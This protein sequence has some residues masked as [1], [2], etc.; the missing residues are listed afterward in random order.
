MEIA[1]NICPCPPVVMM[2][3]HKVVI[4]EWRF[5]NQG[6]DNEGMKNAAKVGRDDV[7]I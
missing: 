4:W 1:R 6:N 7:Y 2:D 3:L 5:K